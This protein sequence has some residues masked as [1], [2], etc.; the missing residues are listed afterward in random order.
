MSLKVLVA[1][2]NFEFKKLR[3]CENSF[4]NVQKVLIYFNFVQNSNSK[5]LS[6]G[7][8]RNTLQQLVPTALVSSVYGLTVHPISKILGTGLCVCVKRAHIIWLTP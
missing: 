8:L 3:N 1:K 7:Y 4:Q 2:D 6:G 5:F